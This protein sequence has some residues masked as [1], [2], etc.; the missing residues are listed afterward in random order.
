MNDDGTILINLLTLLVFLT[1]ASIWLCIRQARDKHLHHR[2]LWL[3][4]T[5]A[6]CMFCIIFFTLPN[7]LHP[8]RY[9]VPVVTHAALEPSGM[10]M[11]GR[12]GPIFI[13]G[14]F[15]SQPIQQL[16]ARG[17]S[18][19]HN[20]IPVNFTGVDA[21]WFEVHCTGFR[22]YRGGSVEHGAQAGQAQPAKLEFK[23]TIHGS[24]N[25]QSIVVSTETLTKLKD[26]VKDLPKRKIRI[27]DT[28][29]LNYREYEHYHRS[30]LTEGFNLSSDGLGVTYIPASVDPSKNKATFIT[31]QFTPELMHSVDLHDR[32][33]FLH[34][35]S[36]P[37]SNQAIDVYDFD[38]FGRIMSGFFYNK[39][40]IGIDF[41]E[42]AIRSS[43]AWQEITMEQGYEG[44]PKAWKQ[45]AVWVIEK[46]GEKMKAE[47]PLDFE[48]EI[49]EPELLRKMLIE[50]TI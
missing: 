34:H 41:R 14:Q 3:T 7:P 8:D 9:E 46:A 31:R 47:I 13:S 27:K 5:G 21:P 42:E 26:A 11:G 16:D 48:I 29:T 10:S 35:I 32:E 38:A 22:P 12:G 44:S 19:T 1:I 30:P 45:E 36:H 15:S 33:V 40:V 25:G 39:T 4:L 43:R 2:P 18:H 37:S 6:V 20:I 49:P 17:L 24:G 28:I 50:G 23:Y